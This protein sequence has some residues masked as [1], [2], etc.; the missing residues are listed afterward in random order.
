MIGKIGLGK[1]K[2]KFIEERIDGNLIFAL[3]DKILQE[4][5]QIS[6]KLHRLKILSIIDGRY[7]VSKY[8]NT[9]C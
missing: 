7:A 4:E 2:E 3:D 9:S 6:M 1:Y 5:L 8:I